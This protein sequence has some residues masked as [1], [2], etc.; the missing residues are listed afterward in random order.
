[1]QINEVKAFVVKDSRGDDTIAVKVFNNHGTFESSSP[2]GKSK[3]MHEAKSYLNKPV[4]DAFAINALSGLLINIP[5][6]EFQDLQK[7]EQIAKNRIGANSLFA[8]EVVLLKALAKEHQ[9]ELWEFLAQELGTK[10]KM[11]YLI[12]NGIG[13][14]MHSSGKKPDFQE[15]QFIPLTSVKDGIEINKAAHIN[16]LQILENIDKKF[17]KIKNDEHAWQTSLSNET[18]LEIMEDVRENIIDE[19]GVKFR[20]G[21][22]V[23]ASSFYKGIGKMKEY[24]YKNPLKIKNREKQMAYLYAIDQ[25]YKLEYLED[26]LQEEDFEGFSLLKSKVKCLVVGDDLTV[27]NYERLKQA[28]TL[29]SISAIIV[30]PNQ[31][32]SLLEVKRVIE[33]AKHHDICIVISHRSGETEDD[34]I[35]DLAVAAEANFFKGGILGKEREVKLNRLKKIEET[36]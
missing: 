31:N 35:A 15:F 9:L 8:L 1:M 25:H 34:F 28:I 33:L 17:K 19:Y 16:A 20:L 22:D 13:G 24:V 5:L 14:G 32:G 2:G 12:G 23:A 36:L 18:V 30:K 3:G 7:V 11:P 29:N 21:I 27:T 6:N 4:G 26:P 10:G